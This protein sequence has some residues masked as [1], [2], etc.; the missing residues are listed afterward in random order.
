MR[1]TC[2]QGHYRTQ[3]SLDFFRVGGKQAGFF[4]PG[5]DPATVFWGHFL[6]P[7]YFVQKQFL[8]KPPTGFQAICFLLQSHQPCVFPGKE[9][10][11]QKEPWI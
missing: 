7:S 8:P 1:G 4:H 2:R 10:E 9:V 11:R 3:A 5:Q 6:T